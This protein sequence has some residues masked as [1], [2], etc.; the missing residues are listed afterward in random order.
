MRSPTLR[1]RSSTIYPDSISTGPNQEEMP[2]ILQMPIPCHQHHD[3]SKGSQQ[4]FGRLFLRYNSVPP[5]SKP[6]CNFSRYQNNGLTSLHANYLFPAWLLRRG[7]S[8][9]MYWDFVS[10]ISIQLSLPRIL[11]ASH[12]YL[13]IK[14]KMQPKNQVLYNAIPYVDESYKD[15]LI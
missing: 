3:K 12:E 4:L 14:F 7:L 1:P 2:K 13:S 15:P 6:P 9:S 8:L 10:R 11:P 5:A